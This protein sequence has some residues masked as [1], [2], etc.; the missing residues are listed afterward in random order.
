M[1]EYWKIPPDASA[2]FVARMEDVLDVYKRPFDP[3]FPVIC[4]DESSQ[5]L[6]GEVRPSIEMAPGRTKKGDDEYERKGVAE[7]FIAIE[8]LTGKR[9]VTIRE[10]RG[11]KE[12][13]EFIEEIV[14]SYYE[15]ATKV[16]L[17][18]DNLNT[19][20]IASLYASF[21]PEK[22][23]DIKERLE[24]HFTPKHGSWLNVAEIGL[25]V[26]KS[27]CLNERVDS[28]KKMQSKVSA[29]VDAT[30]ACTIKIDWQFTTKDARIKLKRL[31]PVF[32]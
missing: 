21:S 12:W 26:L 29:W 2:E 11:R 16:V 18:M 6:I 5:Q 10:H 1:S 23:H 14:F 17:I 20:D 25:S 3:C 8:P 31:Y 28:L 24:I 7:I 27:Q 30:N 32:L 9:H 22:A 15:K 13:A 4:M 19:H